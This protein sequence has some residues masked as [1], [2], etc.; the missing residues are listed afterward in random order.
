MY[1]GKICNRIKLE[2]F[3]KCVVHKI[4]PEIVKSEIVMF[5]GREKTNV[6]DVNVTVDWML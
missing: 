6:A 2:Y 4:N 5:T 3:F 1:H